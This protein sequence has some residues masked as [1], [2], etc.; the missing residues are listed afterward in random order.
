VTFKKV[1][2]YD[3]FRTR[4]RWEPI[5]ALSLAAELSHERAT[6]LGFSASI[7]IPLTV[8]AVVQQTSRFAAQIIINLKPATSGHRHCLY[9]FPTF[10]T[11]ATL[12]AS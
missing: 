3:V 11:L 2:G 5:I 7:R 12:H 10:L 6:F 1:D 9:A 8:R 4:T